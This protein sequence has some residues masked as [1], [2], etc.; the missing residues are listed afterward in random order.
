MLCPHFR[1]LFDDKKEEED[2]GDSKKKEGGKR[3]RLKKGTRQKTRER[4]LRIKRKNQGD[5]R[6]RWDQRQRRDEVANANKFQPLRESQADREEMQNLGEGGQKIAKTVGK[7]NKPESGGQDGQD[8]LIENTKDWVVENFGGEAV[9]KE[10]KEG[11]GQR[12]VK[13]FGTISGLRQEAYLLWNVPAK[14][15]LIRKRK[16][17]SV[18]EESKRGKPRCEFLIAD[19]V[20]GK[21]VEDGVKI[22]QLGED[23]VRMATT[24]TGILKKDQNGE[25]FGELLRK[26]RS[27]RND[28]WNG[29]VVS[30]SIQHLTLKFTQQGSS[31]E[32]M[33]TAVY[34]RC[35][36]IERLELWEEL[37]WLA[38]RLQIPWI[39]GGDFNVIMNE[40]EKLEDRQITKVSSSEA[41]THGGMEEAG[42]DSIFK[43][44]DRV[45]RFG[46]MARDHAPLRYLQ[47]W[48]G[49]GNLLAEGTPFKIL[50]D[51]LKRLNGELS[52]WSKKTYGDF[53]KK[54]ATMEDV[55]K[56]KEVQL[57][58]GPL[59]KRSRRS[60]EIEA[61]PAEEIC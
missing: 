31:K 50:N 12:Q 34:A 58:V 53:F 40:E 25:C 49:L 6:K 46:E 24:P 35:S 8:L 54:V 18:G 36:A 13:V 26:I 57:R 5:E 7:Q 11:N 38:E 4:S 2:K 23:F 55:V 30:D 37:E 20:G 28:D 22:R 1:E 27:L 43:R 41:C 15:G 33:I 39:V 17:T 16:L 60:R 45:Q 29:V 19:G 56:M 3:K 21:G 14:M 48:K 47:I 61:E 10:A 51:K 44:L 32:F 59:E 9:N 42:E 52:G